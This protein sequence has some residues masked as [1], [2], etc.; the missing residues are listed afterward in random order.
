MKDNW[1]GKTAILEMVGGNR[2]RGRGGLEDQWRRRPDDVMDWC[3][4]TL[5][6]AVQLVIGR[7]EVDKITGLGDARGPWVLMN[8]HR[9]RVAR[10][11]QDIAV[12][13]SLRHL[14]RSCACFHAELRPR[15]CC[16]RS[17]S[18]VRSQVRLGRPGGRCQS[19]GRRLM[20]AVM[21]DRA[22]WGV[23]VLHLSCRLERLDYL[24]Q[25][26][27]SKC[28]N[29]EEW[30]SGKD[31]MLRNKDYKSCRLNELKVSILLIT[32]ERNFAR[33]WIS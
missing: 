27:K 9:H 6:E 12:S 30:A 17:S 24:A 13:M 14:E 20:A 33:L 16:W 21:N 26:F 11:W 29:H 32:R 2:P 25:K 3:G 18:I 8:H 19:T 28:D 1:L 15:L 7:E 5:P 10:P 4:R 31:D 23:N 22:Y